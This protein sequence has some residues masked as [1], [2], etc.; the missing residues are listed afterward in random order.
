MAISIDW[1]TKVITVNK[2]DMAVVSVSPEIYELNLDTFRLTLKDLE[3]DEEGMPFLTTHSHVAPITVGG[4]TLARVVELINGYTVTFEDGQ[5]AVNLVGAN[6]NIADNTNVNQVS[7]RASNSAGLTYSTQMEN[8]SFANSSVWVDT[9]NGEDSSQYPVGTNTRPTSSIANA[10]AI[11]AAR[12]MPKKIV[13]ID[14]TYVDASDNL[15]EYTVTGASCH[16]VLTLNAGCI[17]EGMTLEKLVFN[18]TGNG[19]LCADSAICTGLVDFE[20]YLKS[21]GIS[22]EIR[23]TS[24]DGAHHVLDFCTDL[25]SE[26]SSPTFNMAGTA[27]ATLVVRGWSGSIKITNL[28]QADSVVQIDSLSGHIYIDSTC[29]NGLIYARGISGLTDDSTGSCNVVTTDLHKLTISA[30]PLTAQQVRDAMGLTSTGGAASVD[31][32]LNNNF[33]IGAAGL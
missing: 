29:N 9:A 15:T 13:I 27:N 11:V 12:K 1:S 25:N 2:A 30:A 16:T 23:I 24:N 21:C 28:T 6:S 14:D 33:A 5:Y 22:G 4:V 10:T 3:D 8:L 20:G 18:G 31:A 19:A 7:V 17:T 26:E 32:K